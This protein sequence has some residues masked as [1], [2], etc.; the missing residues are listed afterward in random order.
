M[1]L[2]RHTFQTE[3]T[4]TSEVL[5]TPRLPSRS[6]ATFIVYVT[7]WTPAYRMSVIAIGFLW[8][9]PFHLVHVQKGFKVSK[10]EA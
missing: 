6:L 2:G 1:L 10:L 8:K 3:Q 9:V 7:F 5:L 4:G